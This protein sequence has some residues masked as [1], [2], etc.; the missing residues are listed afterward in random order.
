MGMR[1]HE[2][3]QIAFTAFL[4]LVLL[5]FTPDLLKAM[6]NQATA[7][8]QRVTL[9]ELQQ[10]FYKADI[11]KQISVNIEGVT[12][13]EALSKIAE[14]SGFK[15]TYRGDVIEDKMIS[16][17]MDGISVSDAL[18]LVL[19]GTGLDYKISQEGYL[20][21]LSKE[22]TYELE[23]FQETIQGQVTDSDSG[24]PIPGVTIVIQGSD[25]G[26][27]TNV[28][29]NFE[30]TVPS[31]NE[32]LIISAVGYMSQEIEIDGEIIVNISLM[33]DM[34]GLD[35]VVVTGYMEQRRADLTGAVT[36]VSA[37][38]IE[39]NT[40]TNVLQ[41]LQGRIP[42]MY[43]Q[44][45]GSPASGADVQIRGITSVNASPPLVVLD[46]QPVDIHL[47]DIN[48]NDIESIQVLKDAA[49][50]SI[51]GS[52]AAGGVILIETKR[53][54]GE[55]RINYRGSVGVSAFLNREE[56]L[57]TEQYGRG[58]WQAAINDGLDPNDITQIY[59]FDWG[60]D[61]N[62]NPVLNTVTPRECLNT[63]CT[64]RAADTDWIDELTQVGLQNDH[65]ISLTTGTDNFR[66]LFSL[67]VHENQGTQ[68]HTRI[69]RASLRVNTEFDIGDRLTVGENLSISFQRLQNQNHMRS[70]IV[71]PP[72]V[73]VYTDDGGWGGTAM[74]LGMDDYNNPVR[75]AT[76]GA[77]NKNNLGRVVGNVF[78]NLNISENL[79]ARSQFGIN[80]AAQY[81]RHLNRT[82]EEG[83]GRANINSGVNARQ[84]HTVQY[85]FTNTLTY[86]LDFRS[87]QATFMG[88][89]EMEQYLEEGMQGN[90]QD[91]E[92]EDFQYGYFN[93][94]TGT[95]TLNGWGDEFRTLSYF[96]RANYT[97]RS[98]YL[99]SGTLRYDG[100]S[101]FGP[102]NRY[103]LF[104]AVS[105]G[106]RISEESFFS[107]NIS[108][109]VL[110]YL[111]L[112]ASWG[113]N[114][115][116]NIPTN[117]LTN[118]YDANYNATAY[119]ISGNKTGDLPSGYR[120]LRTGN[121]NIMWEA[122]EQTNVGIDFQLFNGIIDGTLDYFN[123]S[124]EGM[125]F[126][127]PYIGAI[128]EGG[129]RWVNAADMTNKGWEA[130]INYSHQTGSDLSWSIGLNMATYSNQIDN[131]P[132]EVR[133]AYG[134]NGI[135]DDIQGRP[136]GSFYGFVTDGIFRTQDEVDAHAEQSGAGIGRIRYKDL[137]GDGVITWEGDRTWL[138]DPNPDLQYG[139]NF[140][141][142]Y[143]NFD[144]TMFFQGIYGIDIYNSW[145][146]YSDFWNVWTQAGFNH[147]TRILNA[148]TPDNPDSDIP[149]LSLSNENDELRMSDYFIE[150]G[151]YLKLRHLEIGYNVPIRYMERLGMGELRV[152]LQGQ[153]I[154]NLYNVFGNSKFTGAEPENASQA[155]EYSFPY[156]RPQTF[157]VGIDLTF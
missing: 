94:A 15:L 144:F 85:T 5:V 122:T 128:G 113:Q 60:M 154:V 23:I 98:R 8:V 6:Q 134:G 103:G 67:N 125:L 53:G 51:Y 93:A 83:G 119:D 28:D 91:I 18:G 140:D 77:P 141:A 79:F 124:T 127:P 136:L 22:E 39:Q 41:G 16:L 96:G 89:I 36:V 139:I 13:R 145:K 99:I 56:M 92:I 97:Y 90:R 4:F 102:E 117:A 24:E 156:L 14:E 57:N 129:H 137:D 75:A 21:I 40:Y 80:Y 132:D 32:T 25:V 59:T 44:T 26:T 78:A 118:L 126:E 47:R 120:R 19:D 87:H 72:I 2:Q 150:R 133:F 52:R 74:G 49:S 100:S 101:K 104:P 1:I 130:Q 43:I 153:N 108:N 143:R 107:D 95:Q 73:P 138:G 76:V 86:N 109:N 147:P 116:S 34:Y 105:A 58:L 17:S 121:P 63:D 82:W 11:E 68:L 10:N 37:E 148:W 50:A 62:G 69:N 66:S 112:R 131:L 45:D 114:G 71:M 146:T 64:M 31:L 3:I 38:A 106:W 155:G 33:P 157:M 55:T 54:R 27:A 84:L 30:L 115:N 123:K 42:G 12:L 151:D 88:G 9:T 7:Q 110:S 29:G 48:P 61:S 65:Q 149:A 142:R 70:A 81:H 111:Q 20:L 152:Y 135:D 46:G 35:E